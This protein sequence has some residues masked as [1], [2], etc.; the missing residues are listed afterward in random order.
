MLAILAS[1][2]H[3]GNTFPC[4]CEA[5]I[6]SIW[7]PAVKITPHCQKYHKLHH[8]MVPI[9]SLHAASPPQGTTLSPAPTRLPPPSH[10]PSRHALCLRSRRWGVFR[11]SASARS[12]RKNR[13]F[14]D[15]SSRHQY[16]TVTAP[17]RRTRSSRFVVNFRYVVIDVS[18][19][20]HRVVRKRL[21]T[22]A[23]RFSTK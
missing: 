7:V 22:S 2:S 5:R 12:H 16:R 4:D 18:L 14:D 17:S 20:R 11:A 23:R 21:Q 1:Q 9:P 6:A 19:L 8:T 15:T 13:R 3:G 10:D